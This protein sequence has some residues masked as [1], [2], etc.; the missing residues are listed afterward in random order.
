MQNP[1]NRI[2]AKA[3]VFLSPKKAISLKK[4]VKLPSSLTKLCQ[5]IKKLEITD[6]KKRLLDYSAKSK[7]TKLNH[8]DT[9]KD[10]SK[11]LAE[12]LKLESQGKPDLYTQLTFRAK[13]N[14]KSS[15]TPRTWQKNEC[16]K[17]RQRKIT[18]ERPHATQVK[19][20]SLRN[21]KS[22]MAS[23]LRQGQKLTVIQEASAAISKQNKVGKLHENDAAA[24]PSHIK[25]RHLPECYLVEEGL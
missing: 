6:Q 21:A 16:S 25:Q 15:A 19:T 17:L 20:T 7:D 10:K 9:H 12:S 14:W 1:K 18:P 13:L 5:G 23:C 24:M 8:R 3:L 2:I 4:S 22:P 11:T